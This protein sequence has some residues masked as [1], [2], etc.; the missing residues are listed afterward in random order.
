MKTWV[1]AL[2]SLGLGSAIGV[3]IIWSDF[4]GATSVIPGEGRPPSEATAHGG[5][6]GFPVAVVEGIERKDNGYHYDFGAMELTG[7]EE[8]TFYVRNAGTGPL[9]L[10]KGHFTCTC[11]LAQLGDEKE[12]EEVVI[13]PGE[14][15]PIVFRWTPKDASDHFMTEGDLITNDPAN[16]TL[17][18]GITGKIVQA[19]RVVPEDLVLDGVSVSEPYQA[20]FT[21][22]EY[23]GGPL[24]V[25][26][27]HLEKADTAPF[28]DVAFE[29]LSPKDLAAERG[30]KGGMEF[31]VTLKSGLPLGP[32]NQKI[33]VTLDREGTSEFEIPIRGR[34]TGDITFLGPGYDAS[35]GFAKLG[36]VS[37]GTGMTRTFH[38]M[39]K[40]PHRR[41]MNLQVA[42][43]RP[44]GV[45]QAELGEPRLLNE[46]AVVMIP[47]EVKIPP[48]SP[49]AD[50]LGNQAASMGLIQLESTGSH[51][52]KALLY[53]SFLIES[54]K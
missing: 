5:E 52:Q 1:L 24:K 18:I 20:K 48:G 34:V 3:C 19:V 7:S 30:A 29:P 4:A 45:L 49:A 35:Q 37:G 36:T 10:K 50:H 53:L 17:R 2:S 8:Y 28:F 46:G 9:T 15:I 43:I 14:S 12:K 39:V 47:L 44:E 51:P 40:G 26:E 25:K 32:I 38:V 13:P 54:S 41:E 16:P 27:Y 21:I 11:T 31:T 33:H 22:Y 6:P 23:R 42:S